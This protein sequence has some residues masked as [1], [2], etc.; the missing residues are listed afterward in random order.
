MLKRSQDQILI[1]TLCYRVPE[2]LDPDEAPADRAKH[3][4]GMRL[5]WNTRNEIDQLQRL[6]RAG[7]KVTPKLL[8]V[9]IEEQDE[10]LMWEKCDESQYDV[11]WWM[12]GGYVVYILMEKLP[13][14]GLT[15]Q[16]FWDLDFSERQAIRASF[17]KELM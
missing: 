3:A 7:S 12:P 16:I 5:G 9:R 13:A 2:A 10:T 15:P 8:A 17:R 1:L 11:R 6:T 14:L 4:L